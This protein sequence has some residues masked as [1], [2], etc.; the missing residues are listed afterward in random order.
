MGDGLLEAILRYAQSKHIFISIALVEDDSYPPTGLIEEITED[1]I[2][3]K[4]FDNNGEENGFS[5]IKK[6]DIYQLF[7]DSLPEQS[8]ALLYHDLNQ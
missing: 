2:C 6:E 4:Q 7:V 8:L 1:S 3:L 5:Y